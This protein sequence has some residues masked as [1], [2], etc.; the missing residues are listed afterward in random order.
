MAVKLTK[1]G[2]I[3]TDELYTLVEPFIN[4]LEDEGT[5]DSRIDEDIS[6]LLG[7]TPFL[8]T[9]KKGLISTKL[10]VMGSPLVWE[11][12]EYTLSE[13]NYWPDMGYGVVRTFPASKITSEAEKWLSAGWAE[14][15]LTEAIKADLQN[16]F[17]DLKDELDA[18]KITQN[19]YLLKTITEGFNDVSATFWPKSAV[20]DSKALFSVDHRV[21]KTDAV[22][23]NIVTDGAI[24]TIG[25]KYAKLTFDSLKKAIAMHRAMKDGQGVRVKRPADGIYDLYVSVEGED[26]ALDVISDGNG[27]MPYNYS[28]TESTNNNY[29]NVFIS[30]DWFKIRL[31][32]IDLLNQPDSLDPDN[33]TIGTADMWFV[34]NKTNVAK[35][36]AFRNI[37]LADVSVEIKR[38][39]KTRAVVASAEK[40][41]GAQILYPEVIV[42]SLWTDTTI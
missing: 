14:W 33:L 2:F 35:R 36:K 10:G 38:D 24:W 11:S 19:E 13:K 4:E 31:N 30:R 12:D 40:H 7:F 37:G 20:Y 27:F 21:I 22:Y 17:G 15:D 23:S 6:S 9:N 16:S 8:P 39:D 32:V 42:G 34:T 26:N 29:T 25:T 3:S 18:I 41:F 1:W 28:G 5:N